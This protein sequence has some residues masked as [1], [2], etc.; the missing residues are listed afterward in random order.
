MSDDQFDQAQYQQGSQIRT[1]TDFYRGTTASSSR[2][3]SRQHT[4]VFTPTPD[5]P[6]RSTSPLTE[7]SSTHTTPAPAATSSQQTKQ[8]DHQQYT[9]PNVDLCSDIGDQ[10]KDIPSDNSSPRHSLPCIPDTPR[11][12]YQT[13]FNTLCADYN[14]WHSAPPLSED[15]DDPMDKNKHCCRR[16]GKKPSA[17]RDGAPSPSG[18][19]GTRGPSP[20]SHHTASERAVSFLVSFPPHYFQDF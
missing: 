14:C 3:H 7:M 6:S 9:I 19:P 16:Q 18:P 12:R 17:P 10:L 1:Q 20:S 8:D 13:S 15:G 5:P 11:E 2:K 4:P